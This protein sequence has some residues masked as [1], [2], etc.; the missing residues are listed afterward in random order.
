MRR[1]SPPVLPLVLR[2]FNNIHRELTRRLNHL[3]TGTPMENGAS[4]SQDQP[5]FPETDNLDFARLADMVREQRRLYQELQPHLDRYENMLRAQQD[6]NCSLS[7]PTEAPPAAEQTD[8]EPMDTTQEP[9]SSTGSQGTTTT[10]GAPW[11]NDVRFCLS[12]RVFLPLNELI[13]SF[14]TYFYSSLKA[15]PRQC[16]CIHTCYIFFRSSMLAIIMAQIH[17]E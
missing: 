16:I 11:C 10:D 7:Q 12:F 4:H 14:F 13:S 3:N 9:G 1:R 15:Y 17:V 5:H 8:A 2:T 6:L